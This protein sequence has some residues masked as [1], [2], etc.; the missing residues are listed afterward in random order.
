MYA[1]FYSTTVNVFLVYIY[2]IILWP[3][4]LQKKILY[5]KHVLNSPFKFTT[6][7]F[8]FVDFKATKIFI[9]CN[10]INHKSFWFTVDHSQSHIS[11]F[12]VKKNLYWTWQITVGFVV[13]YAVQ[14]IPSPTWVYD[15]YVK[16]VTEEKIIYNIKSNN[17]WIL[18]IIVCKNSVFIDPGI[19]DALEWRVSQY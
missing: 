16:F 6:K 12:V 5:A 2:I 9:N 19:L 17:K 4:L 10:L 8:S 18:C 15:A 13:S 3:V 14:N 1:C 11:N 7:Y